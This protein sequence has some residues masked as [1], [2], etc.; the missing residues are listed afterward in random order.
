M[1]KGQV[2]NWAGDDCGGIQPRE[3][4]WREEIE[5]EKKK[6]KKKTMKPRPL[7]A[8]KPSSIA[9]KFNFSF[10]GL[11]EAWISTGFLQEHSKANHKENRHHNPTLLQRQISH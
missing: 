4:L 2:I 1:K 3:F 11:V 10:F 5:E 6:K 7:S 8:Q 9:R